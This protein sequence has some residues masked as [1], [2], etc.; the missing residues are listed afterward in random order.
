MAVSDVS[1]GD[2]GGGPA[3][4]WLWAALANEVDLP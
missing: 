4:G 1:Q 2:V 3:L